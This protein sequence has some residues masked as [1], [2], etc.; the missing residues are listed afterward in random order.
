VT[1]SLAEYEAL[2]LH[3]A[4]NPAALAALRNKLAH[5]RAS[6]PLFD[7]ARFCRD[8]ERAYLHMWERHRRG[9]PPASFDVR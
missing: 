3:L 7:S 6:A 5:Q 9:E 8:L 4:R 2:A 1:T